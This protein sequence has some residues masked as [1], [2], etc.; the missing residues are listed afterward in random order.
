M[1]VYPLAFPDGT[2]YPTIPP[3][4]SVVNVS[5]SNQLA[6]A[7]S[8]AVAGQDIVLANGTY[9]GAFTLS[10]KNGT[11]SS[12]IRIR[13][14][15]TGGATFASG[16]TF[17]ITNCSYVTVQGLVFGF[18]VAGDTFQFRGTSHHCRITRC[19]FGPGTHTASTAVSTMIFVGDD[20]YHIRI[21]HNEIR[22]KGTS[23]NGVR[24]YGSF[25]KVDAGQGSSAGCR[26]VRIDHNIF[27]S[28][29]PEVGND[30]EPVR[31]GVS[32]MSRT[33][34]NG[35]IERN[36]FFDCL[37]EPEVISVKMGR[38][39]TTGNTILRCAGGPVIRHGTN[40]VMADNYIV[41]R[42]NTTASAGLRSGGIRFYDA[43][44]T[45]SYNYID[46]TI[47]ENFQ[48]PLL[49]DTGDAEG[50][51]T[52]LSA[53]WR[54]IGA[55][56]ERNVLV[57]VPRGITIGDNYS[58]AP[59]GCTI[60][61]NLVV[62]ADSG[63][64]VTQRIA[65]TST[66]ITGNQYF[67]STTAAGMVASADTIWRKADFGPR[68]TYLALADVG[69]A[70]DTGDT[71]GTGVELAGGGGTPAAT[72]AGVLNLGTGPGQNYFQLSYAADGAGSPTSVSLSQLAAG[73]AA[74]PYFTVAAGGGAGGS[75][76]NQTDS[77][78]GTTTSS[79]TKISISLAT[80]TTGGT[81][82]AG[83]ARVW[84]SAAG[85]AATRL[86][87]FAYSG[88][89]IGELL[90]VSDEVVVTTTTPDTQQDYVFSG[91]NQFTTTP[92]VQY[93]LGLMW[94]DPGTPS[95]IHSRGS[96]AGVRWERSAS[97][98]PTWTYPNAPATFGTPEGPFDG[99]TEVWV[100]YASGS[101]TEPAV[102]FRVRADSAGSPFPRAELREVRAD[103]TLMAFNAMSGEH[104][105][106][107][108]ARV[109][110][111]PAA[112][113]EVVVA[114]LND[115]VNGERVS[116]R[117]ALISG[118]TRL[119]V[120]LNGAEAAPRLAESYVVGTEFEIDIRIRPGGGVE[121]HYNGGATPI[122][123]GQLTSTGTASWYWALGALAQFDETSVAATEYVAVE[124]RDLLVAHPPASV[125]A[126]PDVSVVA[127][128]LLVIEAVET[129][130]ANVQSRRWI[131]VS[132]PSSPGGGDPGPGGPDLTTAAGRLGWGTPLA[133][134]DE[135]NYSGVPNPDKWKLPGTDWAGHAGNGRRRPERQIVDG[136]K[137][138][139]TGLQNGDSGWMQ[140]KIDLAGGRWEVRLRA[141]QGA[142]SA[143]QPDNTSNGNDYHVLLLIWP[144]S[145]SRQND[146][147]YD[148][149][150]TGVPGAQTAEAYIHFPH[151]GTETVQQ[152]HFEKPGV[153]QTQWHN[154]AIEYRRGS[155]GYVRGFIDGVEWFNTSG[156]ANSVRRDIQDMPA[157][158]LCIQ[159]D[160]F[161]GTNQTP[162]TME[163]DWVRVYSL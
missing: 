75:F 157:G 87:I 57:N 77:G 91:A 107:T 133:I 65:P 38:I 36:V 135:F 39:R 17:R 139:M 8:N 19:T 152:R 18:D 51:S 106:R 61:D 72:P 69:P 101:A 153:D 105:L 103:G 116:V 22:N 99:P 53:H 118:Q 97:A 24:V 140:H 2:A 60:R 89:A 50:S 66:T 120:H 163:V 44:H 37:C 6:T 144:E 90:A 28:I 110:H 159:L 49:L 79:T 146:G 47:G 48:D 14:A 137:L 1:P 156:G 63:T 7:L 46:G 16:S 52:N 11:S 149:V 154:Y 151:P 78:T 85:S 108:R 67:A 80:A 128:Q 130:L 43:D 42:A 45:V 132:S 88:G 125:Y 73:F 33:M 98:S 58:S 147:E 142:P 126:G 112:D 13:A 119:V 93:G 12:G 74:D 86:V 9:S 100:D 40:S 111:L 150:E 27:R 15:N 155:N 92:G 84:L 70:G 71:D 23:G 160:N 114:A 95:V 138:V 83:H 54:V 26:W 82:V 20:S 131:V 161:D 41:D 141:Y 56:V 145:N 109:T 115:G 32:S 34:A 76:G 4:T 121:V 136:N 148:F 35:V 117:T 124:H 30:K 123:T 62:D 122:V 113:P 59:S 55:T 134:S 29:K 3:G 25:A 10:G 158:H 104:R 96:T 94:S 162:A 68:V 5:T 81:I 129:S 21:D 64:A 143:G 127:G 31:Y 102:Q